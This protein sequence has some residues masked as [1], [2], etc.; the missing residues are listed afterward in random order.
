MIIPVKYS[1]VQAA[2]SGN[3]KKL[4]F[5]SNSCKLYFLAGLPAKVSK[6]RKQ[7]P[8]MKHQGGA[9]RVYRVMIVDDELIER[10]GLSAL[11]SAHGYPFSFFLAGDGEE[12]L[13]IIAGGMIPDILITDIRMPFVDGME[14]I[15][16]VHQRG[17]ATQIIIYSAYDE[18]Q[19]ARQALRCGVVDYLLKPV[20]PDELFLLLDQCLARLSPLQPDAA[21]APESEETCLCRR[22][23]KIIEESY[24][25]DIGLE[26][27]AR[28]LSHSVSH[29]SHVFARQTGETILKYLT[30][31]RMEKAA[32]YLRTSAY[33]ISEISEMVGYASS[34]YFGQ[35]F[36]KYYHMTPND[37]REKYGQ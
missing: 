22:I 28:A 31:C 10:K 20:E 35:V 25:Q 15:E 8:K 16:A 32:A 18:F 37:Y 12:A 3:F 33:Q 19:Y 24:A 34:A 17:L 26:H 9:G 11:I 1:I 36:R 30:R 4:L 6:K 21:P 27:I 14:L 23:K 2:D 7:S 5:F 13:Q 29:I